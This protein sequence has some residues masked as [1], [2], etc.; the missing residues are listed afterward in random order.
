MDAIHVS[1]VIGWIEQPNVS[2]VHVQVWEPS[3]GSSFT[4]DLAGIR[5]PLDCADW[6]VSKDEIG[7]QSA[8]TTGKQMHGS[9]ILIS[10]DVKKPPRG[11]LKVGG[12]NSG[13][14]RG[15]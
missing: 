14:N 12:E 9:H 4:Q 8:T 11:R 5:F 3:I 7:E 15:W 1:G 13:G 6:L 10:M 2:F